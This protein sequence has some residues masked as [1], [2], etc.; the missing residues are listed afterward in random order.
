MA[1]LGASNAFAF[2]L[3]WESMALL[4]ALLVVGLRP[5]RSVASAGYLYLAMTHVATAALLMA[6]AVLAGACGGRLDFEAWRAAAP[7]L[8]PLVR[9][10]AFLLALAAFATKA[11][12]VP[13]HSWLPRAHPVAPS[14]VSAVMSGIMIKTG[15]YGL[16]RIA[17]DLLGGGA[18]WWGVLILG[19]GAVSAV[20]G[21]LY[22]LMQHD[23]K[24]LLAYHSIENI[25]IIL[26]GL[27]SAL[28]LRAHGAGGL[29]AL[30]LAAAL[31]HSINHAVFKTL[32]FLGA[33]AVVHATNLR[34]L[35]HLGGLARSMP[36][37]ALAFGIGAA[38]ISG[39]PPL[40]GFASEWLVFQG[41]LGTAGEAGS[42]AASAACRGGHDRG[43]GPDDGPGRGLLR[44][45]DGRHFPG[46]AAQ[47]R[48]GGGPRDDPAGSQSR[49]ASWPPSAWRSGWA[50][51]RSSRV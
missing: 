4:S 35:N 19:L 47:R 14:H 26:I 36:A 39:L 32:L 45:G 44:Q 12:A 51:G 18:D 25:G 7:T 37:T 9:D 48:G 38:A 50:P 13:V 43:A 33:G 29:A 23:L 22:A 5:S 24:R 30:A 27:G 15:I 41:L 28:I 46:P 6:F 49:W 40:N 10:G 3:A 21:V 2:L 11:G 16:M 34:D 20:L 8:A 31:F 17:V 42:P 1:V